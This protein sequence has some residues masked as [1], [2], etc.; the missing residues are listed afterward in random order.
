VSSKGFDATIVSPYPVSGGGNRSA[1]VGG[2]VGWIAL[3]ALFAAVFLRFFGW[4]G[5]AGICDSGGLKSGGHMPGGGPPR[6]MSGLAI[7]KLFII[8]I[9]VMVHTLR[10]FL[11]LIL[12]FLSS[13]QQRIVSF[14]FVVAAVAVVVVVVS[15]GSML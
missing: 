10:D 5:A 8:L 4:L 11:L 3:L 7:P 6:N 14:F 13:S 1:G 9:N 12:F 2:G 15:F